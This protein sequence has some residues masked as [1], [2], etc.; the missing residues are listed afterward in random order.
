MLVDENG[1]FLTQRVLPRMALI[2]PRFV[3]DDLMVEAPGMPP[4]RIR[5]GAGE[6]EWIPVQIW[7]DELRLPHPDACYSEW[8]SS[9]LGQRCRLMNLPDSVSRP[10]EAPYD[11]A[12]WR[13]S[14]ADSFPVLAITQASLDLLNSKLRAPITMARFRPNV[15]ISGTEPH[16]E[17]AW[18]RVRMGEVEL[19]MA[20]LC[21]RC[22]IPQ[23]DPETGET[24]LE[25]LQTL[26]QYRRPER[27]VLFGHKG[28]VSKPGVLRVGDA[29]EVLE[30]STVAFATPATSSPDTPHRRP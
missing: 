11:Q 15:V 20:K 6:G 8:F 30:E 5:G 19:K 10:V 1:R 29:V 9:F 25:P 17:D 22:A 26:A 3:G 21:V 7:R 14:L 16:E 28:L 18:R 13:V 24:G 4:L 2:R 23:V 12:P 27:K